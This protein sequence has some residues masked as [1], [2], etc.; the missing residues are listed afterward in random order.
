MR[1]LDHEFDRIR[2]RSANS[3]YRWKRSLGRRMWNNQDMLVHRVSNRVRS[4]VS[5]SVGF[6]IGRVADALQVPR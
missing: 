3:M 4:Y 6:E 1:R 5:V 2:N